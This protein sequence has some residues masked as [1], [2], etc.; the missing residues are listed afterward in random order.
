MLYWS[1]PSPQIA[2]SVSNPPKA[3]C[4]E[5]PDENRIR[6]T[7]NPLRGS[8]GQTAI[9]GTSMITKVNR[10]LLCLILVGLAAS[11]AVAQYDNNDSKS[12]SDVRTITGCLTKGDSAK[13][14]L[15]TANDGSTWEVRDS[16]SA[17]LASHVGHT[18]T[19]KGVVSNAKMHNMKEDAKDAA[20]DSGM[21][22]DNTEHGHLKVTDVTMVSD[23]CQK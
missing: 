4:N 3:T 13:E 12:K 18:V 1:R 10:L 8:R 20:K 17:D 22:K 21:K 14:F 6:F 23:S 5:T 2:R 9:G 11:W 15:L 7:M 19:A 16:G